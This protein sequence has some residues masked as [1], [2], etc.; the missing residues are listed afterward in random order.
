MLRP[1]SDRAA[2]IKNI[3]GSDRNCIGITFKLAVCCHAQKQLSGFNL[4]K[5]VT[6]IFPDLVVK[7]FHANEFVVDLQKTKRL[8]YRTNDGC[9]ELLRCVCS[10]SLFFCPNLGRLLF[11]PKP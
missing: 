10:S 8:F 1:N 7:K 2:R 11:I 5:S 4:L 3:S 9:I 6:E